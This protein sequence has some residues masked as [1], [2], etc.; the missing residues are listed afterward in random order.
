MLH[1]VCVVHVFIDNDLHGTQK[2][3][4]VRFRTERHP[5]VGP[6]GRWIV[7]RRD[8]HNTRTSL[9][10]LEFPVRFRHFV[11]D[12]ILAPTGVQLGETH[13]REVDVRSLHTGPEWVS[14]ILVTVPCVV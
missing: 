12:E 3:R 2:Q 5:V 13:V 10:T 8:D 4:S 11:L 9:N 14:R 7:L 6:I 1:E